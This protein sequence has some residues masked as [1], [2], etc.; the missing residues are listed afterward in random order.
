VTV[1]GFILSW[2]LSWAGAL[3]GPGLLLAG[4]GYLF[5]I[6]M[7]RAAGILVIVAGVW[8]GSGLLYQEGADYVQRQVDRAVAEAREIDAKETTRILD[9]ANA[10]TRE[11]EEALI[12]VRGELAAYV[13]ELARRPAD[14]LCI[15]SDA[16]FERLR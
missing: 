12:A 7:R 4:A 5:F 16:D 15:G 10:R 13:D 3:L 14:A 6:G 8:F 2:L 11:R 1:T 9:D